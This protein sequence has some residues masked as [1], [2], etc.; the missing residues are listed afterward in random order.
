MRRGVV[1]VDDKGEY[2]ESLESFERVHELA[3][4]YP[5]GWYWHGRA[6]YYLERYAESFESFD[7]ALELKHSA[8]SNFFKGGPT[9][10]EYVWWFWRGVAAYNLGRYEDALNSFDRAIYKDS[11][12]KA[13]GCNRRV[14]PEEWLWH[15]KTL[16]KLGKYSEA[17]KSFDKELAN[18]CA[19]ENL[20]NEAKYY[21]EIALKKFLTST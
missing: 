21:R 15:G 13:M 9:I 8:L 12:D 6:L 16:I 11:I 1:L 14:G 4:K 7:K 17:I 3:P 18:D 20:K 10:D 2:E 5:D 19:S